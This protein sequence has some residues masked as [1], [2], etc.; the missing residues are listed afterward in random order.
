MPS[1]VAT[2]AKRRDGSWGV[3][4]PDSAQQ[5]GSTFRV[6]VHK[7]NGDVETKA[8]RVVKN[9]V[10]HGQQ[11]ALC[12]IVDDEMTDVHVDDIPF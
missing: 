12:E 2:F 8:V 11:V 1:D 9:C 5:P 6:D 7:R 10:H 3:R 4:V